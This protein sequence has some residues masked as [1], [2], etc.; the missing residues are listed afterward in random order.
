L[1]RWSPDGSTIAFASDRR[2]D[3][4]IFV[5]HADGS[6][7]R[8]LTKDGGW[9]VWWPDGSQIGYIAVGANGNGEIRTVSL[10]D[11]TARRLESVRLATLN[12]P[13][14]LFPDGVR[15]VVGN[16]VHMSDEIWVI[17]PRR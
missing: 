11:G 6:G 16:A 12:H 13:F 5:I 4:G 8:Q 9:P 3:G 10:R 14:A 2:Y 1:P 7:E 15:L 17:E